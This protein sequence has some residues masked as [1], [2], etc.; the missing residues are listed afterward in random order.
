MLLILHD[1]NPLICTN[2]IGEDFNLS[3]HH[4][5]EQRSRAPPQN[6][7]PIVVALLITD[8]TPQKIIYYKL[9]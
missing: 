3:R 8:E 7:S 5:A 2:K 9:L 4:T 6:V 1:S